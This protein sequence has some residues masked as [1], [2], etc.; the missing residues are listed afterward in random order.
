ML[1]QR[2]MAL[3]ITLVSVLIFYL[4]WREAII[5]GSYYLKA[6]AFTPLGIVAGIFL[7]IFPQFYGKPESTKEKVVGFAVLLV[8]MLVG[9]F[10]W[11]LI[12]PQRFRF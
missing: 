7:M 1:K 10:N 6:A 8:G 11:Y 12:D 5:K 3:I 2:I 4:T 9:L